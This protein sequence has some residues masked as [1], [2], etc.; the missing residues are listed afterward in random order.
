[1]RP[2]RL[3]R[4]ELVGLGRQ[5][6]DCHPVSGRISTVVAALTLGVQVVPHGHHLPTG[7]LVGGFQRRAYRFGESLEPALAADAVA[8]HL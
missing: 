8:A 7:L 2:D 5:M 6:E 3:D 4:V 1:M